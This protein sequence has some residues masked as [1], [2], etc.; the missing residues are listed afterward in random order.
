[1]GAILPSNHL[2]N[3]KMIYMYTFLPVFKFFI[4]GE[5]SS[6]AIKIT[7]KTESAAQND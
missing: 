4:F 7:E 6:I 1:M 3:F 5:N 2:G